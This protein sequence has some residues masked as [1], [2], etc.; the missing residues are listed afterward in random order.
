M[1][2]LYLALLSLIHFISGSLLGG[3]AILSGKSV[4]DMR[5]GRRSRAP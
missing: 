3:L 4:R 5:N 2:L 1:S